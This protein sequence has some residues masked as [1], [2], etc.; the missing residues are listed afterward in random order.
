MTRKAKITIT[1]TTI[2]IPIV[3]EDYIK[4]ICRHNRSESVNF[5][6]AGDCRTPLAAH[7]FCNKMQKKYDIEILYMDVKR[8][9]KYLEKYPLLKNFL[10][11]NCIQRRNIAILKAFEE[12]AD[13]IVLIDDDNFIACDDY[14]GKHLHLGINSIL[15]V[16]SSHTGWYNICDDLID[17]QDRKFYPRGYPLAE[18]VEDVQ[19]CVFEPREMRT[20]V[21]AGFWLGDPDIDAAT[22][23]SAPIDVVTYKRDHNYALDQYVFAPFNSQNTALFR[24]IVPVYFLVSDIGRFDDI[25]ASYIVERVAWH[26]NDYISYGQPLVRQNRNTH[27]L[28]VDAFNEEMGTRMT[29]DFCRWLREI[30]ISGDSY[31]ECGINLFKDLKECI[32]ALP[33]TQLPFR[34]RAYIN[35]FIDGYNIWMKTFIRILN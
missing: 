16:V 2:N 21:N 31:L 6:I 15:P 23:L 22:R 12:G 30:Q 13:I 10:P 7:A 35:H 1:T 29:T 33:N 11:W 4:D 28:W 9:E 32:D 18:R 5:I 27:D 17:R 26:K 8:Q 34:N 24:D 25:W 3:I 19:R 14:I 20:V